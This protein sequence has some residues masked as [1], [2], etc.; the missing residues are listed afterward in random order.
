MT[1]ETG[2]QL[3]VSALCTL[4]D[5]SEFSRETSKDLMGVLLIAG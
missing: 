2:S 1:S 5:E 4:E 3:T